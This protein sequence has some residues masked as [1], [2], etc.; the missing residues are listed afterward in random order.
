MRSGATARS[1]HFG[2]TAAPNVIPFIDVLLVLLV[3]FIVTAPAPTTDLNVNL[4]QRGVTATAPIHPTFVDVRGGGENLQLSVDGRQA[5]IG[6]LAEAVFNHAL[7]NNPQLSGP[8]I[9]GEAAI[10]VRADQ[11]LAYG[12]VVF[13]M[14]ELKRFRFERVAILLPA[15]EPG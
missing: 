6:T 3:I 14:D 10:Y 2:V 1:G 15:G 5:D 12:D 7:S 9:L 4:P 8:G 11:A 13:V